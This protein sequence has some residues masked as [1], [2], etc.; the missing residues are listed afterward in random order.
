MTQNEFCGQIRATSNCRLTRLDFHK[1]K[2]VPKLDRF[3]TEKPIFQAHCP[4]EGWQKH[5]GRKM[6]KSRFNHGRTRIDMDEK[7]LRCPPAEGRRFDIS[8]NNP[9]VINTRL[10]KLPFPPGKAQKLFGSSHASPRHFCRSH[11]H[12]TAMPLTCRTY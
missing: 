4:F 9:R 11:A 2:V 12:R 1:T 10:S 5:S 8:K 6:L 7:V 3:L